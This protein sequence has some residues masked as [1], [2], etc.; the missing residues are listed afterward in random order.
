MH[1]LFTHGGGFV[2]T[3]HVKHVEWKPTHQLMKRVDSNFLK[4][5]RFIRRILVSPAINFSHLPLIIPALSL[6]EKIYSYR[7]FYDA[8]KIYQLYVVTPSTP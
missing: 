8:P 2:Q 1:I 3:R 6:V 4:M 5:N 7:S